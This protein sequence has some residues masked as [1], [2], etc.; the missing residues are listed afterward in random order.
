MKKILT[1]KMAPLLLVSV[2]GVALVGCGSDDDDSSSTPQQQQDEQVQGTYQGTFSPVNSVASDIGGT[3][4]I[5]VN[6]DDVQI[7][8]AITGAPEG[9]HIQYI[10]TGT[11]CPTSAA[12][13]NRD[14]FVDAAE[15]QA[16][17]GQIL[18]PLDGDIDSQ[19]EGRNEYPSGANYNYDEDSS[20][21][22]M[23][24][25]LTATDADPNDSVVKLPAGTT[26]QFGGQVIMIHGIPADTVLPRT[27]AGVDDL[28]P[29]QS[30]PIACAVI[31]RTT[32]GTTGG[33]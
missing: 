32:G 7:N 10:A 16:V 31:E 4:D 3:A 15:A 11:A 8:M 9:Q 28:T 23:V 33:M 6:G 24:T 18:V 25:D 2:M 27:V 20:L 12:D 26:L 5:N 14:G 22:E 17:A 21:A 13:T 19:A 29:A 30:L 1:K